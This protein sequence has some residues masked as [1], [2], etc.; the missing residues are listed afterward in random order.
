MA[1]VMAQGDAKAVIE[2][3]IKAHGGKDLLEKFPASSSKFK[4]EM[5]IMGLD[6]TF[7]GKG[8]QGPGQYKFELAADVGGQKLSIV[9]IVDGA[10]VKTKAMLGGMDLPQPTDEGAI[11]E[12]K[13]A[14]INQEV[15]QLTPLL[16]NTKKYSI[17][18]DADDDVDGKKAATVVVT[19]KLDGDK[20]KEMKLFFDKDNGMLVKFGRNG[21]SPGGDGKEVLQESVMSDFKSVDGLMVPMKTVTYIE[22]KKFMTMQQTE[23]KILEKLD[24]KDMKSDD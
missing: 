16:S 22:G 10:K 23:H 3:A 14:L 19:V 11:D 21:L 24:P 13:F 7:E 8:V 1:P 9:Q 17:K 4:G 18:A 5:S 2:K 12:L 6:M 20:T 15:T